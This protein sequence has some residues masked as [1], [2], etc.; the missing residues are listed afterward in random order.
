MTSER[1]VSFATAQASASSM[2]VC[3]IRT[4]TCGCLPPVEV[5]CGFSFLVPPLLTSSVLQTTSRGPAGLS[6]GGF[7]AREEL[8][9]RAQCFF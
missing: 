6:P 2:S 4:V 5:G 1:T 8:S 3:G 9:Y 7:F